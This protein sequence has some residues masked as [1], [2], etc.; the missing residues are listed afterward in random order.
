MSWLATELK[1][2]PLPAN[3]VLEDAKQK[4]ISKK[5]L[6]RAKDALG[7]ESKKDGLGGSWR[8]HPVEDGQ[9]SQDGQGS[10]HSQED[11]MVAGLAS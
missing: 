2:M 4:G 6:Y 1:D 7:V 3:T 8:W 10:Q 9:D 11:M 5:T